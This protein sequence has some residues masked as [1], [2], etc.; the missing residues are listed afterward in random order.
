MRVVESLRLRI[1][2]DQPIHLQAITVGGLI[3]HTS[4]RNC[5]SAIRPSVRT[6]LL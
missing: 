5:R 1:N 3:E 6:S 2:S 4:L